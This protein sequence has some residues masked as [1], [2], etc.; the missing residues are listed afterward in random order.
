MWDA[1]Q[2]T[3]F[4][5]TYTLYEDPLGNGTGSVQVAQW[6]DTQ[7]TANAWKD[8]VL[9]TSPSAKSPSGNYFYRLTIAGTTTN[10]TINCFKVRVEGATYITPTSIFGL[11]AS[12]ASNITTDGSYDGSWD[13]AMVVPQG[14][15]YVGVWDG[16]FDYTSDT[17]DPNTGS[18]VPTWSPSSAVAEGA[19]PGN[20]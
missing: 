3:N 9:N 5:T 10:S 13:F 8:F 19:H 12:K 4:P 16:D 17:D 2:T 6:T 7:M 20:P 11:I 15:T 1:D 14:S 18:T